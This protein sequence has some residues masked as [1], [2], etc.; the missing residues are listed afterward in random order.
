MWAGFLEEGAECCA[1]AETRQLI[2]TLVHSPG[3]PEV[4]GVSALSSLGQ[5]R[6]SWGFCVRGTTRVDTG[7]EEPRP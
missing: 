6:Q 4:S 1:L 2:K 3:S 5:K 7:V